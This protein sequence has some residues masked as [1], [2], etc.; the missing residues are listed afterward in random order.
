MTLEPSKPEFEKEVVLVS[1]GVEST[2]ML[3]MRHR[4]ITTALQ[5]TNVQVET[6]LFSVKDL[7]IPLF[8]N[9]GVDNLSRSFLSGA[10][11]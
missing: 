10:V 1:G 6:P 7:I 4:A 11:L 8:I 3:H 9:Y 5:H 2:T